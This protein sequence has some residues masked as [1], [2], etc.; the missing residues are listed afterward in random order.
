MKHKLLLLLFLFAIIFLFS[1]KDHRTRK[2]IEKI[3]KEWIGKEILFPENILCYVAG[4]DTLPE[5]CNELFQ[6]EYKILMYVDS[7]GCSDCRLR[8]SDWQYLIEEADRQSRISALFPT[9]K[10]K[11]N[12]TTFCK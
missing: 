10:R 5:L 6:K 9:Q 1:C 11:S 2:E 4:K 8:L 7:V 12:G 3:L